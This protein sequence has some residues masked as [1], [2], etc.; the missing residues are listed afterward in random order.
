VFGPEQRRQEFGQRG[1][2]RGLDTDNHQIARADVFGCGVDRHF[3]QM[4]ALGRGLDTDAARHDGR[5][6]AADEKM[7]LVAGLRQARAIIAAERAG[8]DN[9]DAG[10]GGEG[11]THNASVVTKLWRKYNPAVARAGSGRRDFMVFIHTRF[12]A[13]AQPGTT[14]RSSPHARASACNCGRAFALKPVIKRPPS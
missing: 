3:F 10:F 11:G 7:D 2:G 1:V 9:G 4:E 5:P 13:V 6:A 14:L 8:S 12:R